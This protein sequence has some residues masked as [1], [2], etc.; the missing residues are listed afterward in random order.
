MRRALSLV[1][2]VVLAC[3]VVFASTLGGLITLP[4]FDLA[5]FFSGNKQAGEAPSAAA[6]PGAKDE[7]ASGRA[8]ADQSAAVA[9]AARPEANTPAATP[10]IEVARVDP[11]GASVL[12]GRAPAESKV[13]LYA[14]GEA[15]ATVTASPDGQWSAVVTKTFPPG[16][17]EFS[18]AAE[19]PSGGNTRG[20]I[21]K[22]E[23]PKGTG[24]AE[25]T[26]TPA[27]PRPILPP[28]APPGDSHAINQL[29]ALVEQ[30]KASGGQSGGQ[31]PAMV[32]V[33]IT[34]VTGEATMT[35][36]GHRA[37]DLLVE[38]V[39]IMA[40]KAMTLSG[41]ADDR[42]GD[43]YNVELSRQR[44]EAI[45]NYLR[46]RG[47]AGRL[48]LLPKGKSEPFMGIDRHSAA[49]A[50]ILQ[51]DRRVELRLVE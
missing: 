33:P 51:A 18:I 45:E 4:P 22:V 48:S 40:P 26:A 36:E 14:N 43:A 11:D 34:F 3:G 35:A 10:K 27:T 8:S 16:P 19:A 28:K 21:L 32:P 2:A 41:H 42:G 44:L 30:A 39:R 24:L 46:T 20:P 13:T 50:A 9:P 38:Y 7:R 6:P 1:L 15:I 49:H 5:S 31:V 12:A 47:Y 29:A 23:V 37:A 17:L 25:L